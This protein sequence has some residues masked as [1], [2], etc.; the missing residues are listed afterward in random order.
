MESPMTQAS[1][2]IFFFTNLWSGNKTFG[3]FRKYRFLRSNQ[4]SFDSTHACMFLF[5]GAFSLN[6]VLGFDSISDWGL[7]RAV[8]ISF[9][10]K[11]CTQRTKTI[12]GG[13]V[14]SQLSSWNCADLMPQSCRQGPGLSLLAGWL[15][16]LN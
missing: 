10:E 15:I 1:V 11:F 8:P 2:I 6:L 7:G 9:H 16:Q 12:E 13:N 5:R 3:S 4:I 14:V